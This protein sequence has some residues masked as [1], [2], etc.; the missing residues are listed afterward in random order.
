MNAPSPSAPLKIAIV[1]CGAMG[2][3]HLKSILRNPGLRL[4]GLCDVNPEAFTGA[5]AEVPRF[6]KMEELF[7]KVPL[8]LAT[9]VLPNY[10]YESAVELAAKHKVNVLCEKPLGHNLESCRRILEIARRHGIRGWVSSQRKYMPHFIAARE[11]LAGFSVDFINVIFTYYWEPAF[12]GMGW[13]GDRE[14]SGGVAVI[15]SGWHVFDA[16]QWL[17]GRPESVFAQLS[18]TRQAPTIDDKAAIQLR[19]PSGTLAN[20]TISYTTPKDTFDFLFTDHDRALQITYQHMQYFEGG[21]LV[22]SI[23]AKGGL[24]MIDAMYATL[25]QAIE[26]PGKPAYI[27]TFDQAESIMRA[28]DG[29]YRSAAEGILVRLE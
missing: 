26:E 20:L 22:E 16:L 6:S 2:N 4:A 14:K 17:M 15:D 13:R 3:T 21:K 7:E 8:D 11:K 19:Y 5:P 10:L 28:I 18:F 24:E 25:L 23:E 12:R 29:A 27:T 9:L 1:G